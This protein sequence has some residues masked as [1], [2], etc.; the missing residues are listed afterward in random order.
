M[1][2]ADTG[3]ILWTGESHEGQTGNTG[4]PAAAEA[5]MIF[6]ERG[7]YVLTRSGASGF[8]GDGRRLWTIRLENAASLPAF[9]DEGILYLG[10]KEWTLHAYRLEERVKARKQPFYGPAPE[11]L[12]GTGNPP[13]SPWADFPYR[14]ENAQ[15]KARLERARSAINTGTLGD[16]EMAYTADLMELA[17]AAS[18]PVISPGD[19]LVQID[20]RVQA[21]RL[22]GLFGSRETIPFLVKVFKGDMEPPVK[23][24]AVEAIGRIGVDPDDIALPAFAGFLSSSVRTKD[25]RILSALVTATASL[26]RFSGPPLSERGVKLLVILSDP[27]WSRS[28]QTQARKELKSLVR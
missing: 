8:T 23:A 26:C 15:I 3:R 13:P 1:V 6:D 21:L 17:G 5:S 22:L 24:A 11:G 28:I 4:D 27:P 9:S 14:F 16:M 25:E 18:A 12:Y 20:H 10:A 19:P 2:Q 7:I